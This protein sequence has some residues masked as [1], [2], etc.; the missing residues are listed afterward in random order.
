MNSAVAGRA[1]GENRNVVVGGEPGSD[2]LINQAGVASC[3]AGTPC[4]FFRQPADDRPAP[5]FFLGNE[6]SGQ[7]GIDDQDVEP[8]DVVGDQQA[9]QGAAATSASSRTPRA[10]STSADQRRLKF[11]RTEVAPG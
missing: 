6:G 11:C 10:S 9:A 5:D 1:F 4:H 3:P 7:D 8:G 2:F